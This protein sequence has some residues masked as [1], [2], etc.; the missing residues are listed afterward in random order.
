MQIDFKNCPAAL[1]KVLL[2]FVENPSYIFGV[3]DPLIPH[4]LQLKNIFNTSRPIIAALKNYDNC[5][6]RVCHNISLPNGMN[7][8]V[9]DAVRKSYWFGGQVLFNST[10]PLTISSFVQ[11]LLTF[12][13]NKVVTIFPITF[14]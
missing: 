14:D 10:A 6:C 9:F 13:D 11:E 3:V 2:T 8:N 12:M 1:E 4:L 7:T 5:N